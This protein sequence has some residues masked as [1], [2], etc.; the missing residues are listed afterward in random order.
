MYMYI[1]SCLGDRRVFSRISSSSIPRRN[2][3]T[4]DIS[5]SKA[6]VYSGRRMSFRSTLPQP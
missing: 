5:C 4:S 2:I 3:S 6:S 1:E